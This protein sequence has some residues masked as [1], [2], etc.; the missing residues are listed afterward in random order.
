MHGYHGIHGYR[1]QRRSAHALTPFWRMRSP[2]HRRQSRAGANQTAHVHHGTGHPQDGHRDVQTAE[3]RGR[4]VH[5]TVRRS[6]VSSRA[7]S[8]VSGARSS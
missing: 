6:S 7:R 3:V 5:R 8:R 4:H 2:V 1:W